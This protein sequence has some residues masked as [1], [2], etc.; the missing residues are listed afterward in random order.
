MPEVYGGLGWASLGTTRGMRNRPFD[1]VLLR[2]DGGNREVPPGGV[3]G[4]G[5]PQEGPPVS[6]PGGVARQRADVAGLPGGGG[7]ALHHG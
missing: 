5:G 7:G 6:D 2:R 1:A 4:P 3:G